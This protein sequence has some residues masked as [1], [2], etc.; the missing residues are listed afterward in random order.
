MRSE[1]SSGW[2]EAHEAAAPRL[3][4]AHIDLQLDTTLGCDFS[5][6]IPTR[7]R[8]D[9]GEVVEPVRRV[10]THA[11]LDAKRPL[12]SPFAHEAG[13]R[14]P[15]IP[16]RRSGPES[17]RGSVEVPP[18]G[19]EFGDAINR[20]LGPRRELAEAVREVS[21]PGAAEAVPEV[22][23]SWAEFRD[24][25]GELRARAADILRGPLMV[26]DAWRRGDWTGNASARE[27]VRDAIAQPVSDSRL[28]ITAQRLS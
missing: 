20:I 21:A 12:S 2:N 3:R 9:Y 27:P 1:F 17:R 10:I 15:E 11:D 28:V 16:M 24:G 23:A 22:S 14:L 7:P 4:A 6:L 8:L 25:P 26:G 18:Y 13:R 19:R 5:W